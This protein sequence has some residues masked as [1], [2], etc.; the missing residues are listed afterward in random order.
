MQKYIEAKAL[1]DKGQLEEALAA[2]NDSIENGP[3]FW[4]LRDRAKLYAE[5]GQDEAA[6]K[7]C[8]AAL[9]LT[10]EDAD[11][12]WIKKELSKPVAQRFQ[13]AAKSAPSSNR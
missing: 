4:A 1:L 5:R 2:L 7:D 13:G 8:E 11:V 12:L 6:K 9:E 3:T 10:P